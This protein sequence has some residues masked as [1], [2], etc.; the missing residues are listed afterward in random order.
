MM[1][2]LGQSP[3]V[4]IRF[5]SESDSEPVDLTRHWYHVPRMLDIV[6]LDGAP[7]PIEV[8]RVNWMERHDPDDPDVILVVRVVGP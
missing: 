7:G 6:V 5:A 3:L 8:T 4:T 1:A 2:P